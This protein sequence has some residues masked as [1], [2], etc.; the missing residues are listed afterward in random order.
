MAAL[1]LEEARRARSLL[2]PQ[3]CAGRVPAAAAD[4]LPAPFY[5]TANPR[6][7]LACTDSFWQRAAVLAGSVHTRGSL[8]RAGD[9]LSP[10]PDGLSH[11]TAVQGAVFF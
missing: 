4:A 1:L 10:T 11:A 3:S 8:V 2:S 5:P 9:A 7:G 6:E